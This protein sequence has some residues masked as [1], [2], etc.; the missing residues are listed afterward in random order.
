M[1]WWC[2]SEG[3]SFCSQ[4]GDVHGGSAVYGRG[5]GHRSGHVWGDVVPTKTCHAQEPIAWQLTKE[6]EGF[7]L[8]FGE[9]WLTAA[10]RHRQP[11]DEQVRSLYMLITS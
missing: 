2:L 6:R 4:V 7:R 8:G 5:C 11:G 9:R 1:G 10:A 3:A